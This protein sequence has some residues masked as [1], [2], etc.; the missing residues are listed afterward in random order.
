MFCGQS[1]HLLNQSVA[2]A[3][4]GIKNSFLKF[5]KIN[6]SKY[7]MLNM[8]NAIGKRCIDIT[9]FAIDL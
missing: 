7:H 3:K 1:H 9:H 5:Q 8:T 2:I 4:I 6:L